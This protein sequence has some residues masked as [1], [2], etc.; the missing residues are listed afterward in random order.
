M[1]LLKLYIVMRQS[2]DWAN[3]TYKDL[4]KTRYF[5]RMI[6]RAEDFIVKQ[7][8]LWD[9][10]FG[11]SFFATR[12]AMKE[13]S[14]DNFNSVAGAEVIDLAH[15]RSFLN[16][17]AFY[18]FTDDDDWYDPLIG[19]IISGI[20]PSQCAAAV[21]GSLA[22]GKEI[23]LRSD[24]YFYTNSYAISGS[25][26]LK[27][28][29]NLDRV[30]QHFRAQK[31]FH[32]KRNGFI[33]RLGRSRLMGKM[34]FPANR[35]VVHLDEYCSVT[36][37]HPASTLALEALGD[38]LTSDKMRRAIQESIDAHKAAAVPGEFVWAQPYMDRVNDFFAHLL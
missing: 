14:L 13:I 28:Y 26:L 8:K 34:F 6:G 37:K 20:D 31:T 18:L 35:N 23:D 10:T 16:P 21:W 33:A 29:S 17:N 15:V 1:N 25:F 38:D 22:Y 7:V 3:Q 2:P 24:G 36:N 11:T 4:E 27:S 32:P 12:Q 9:R 19:K 30:S 5:C